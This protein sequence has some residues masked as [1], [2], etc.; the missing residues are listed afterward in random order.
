[1][2]SWFWLFLHILSFMTCYLTILFH[3]KLYIPKTLLRSLSW[4]T[5]NC[6]LLL[7]MGNLPRWH[8]IAW[9]G[10]ALT[11]LYTQFQNPLLVCSGSAW[12]WPCAQLLQ[13]LVPP[14]TSPS[15]PHFVTERNSLSRVG[16]LALFQDPCVS[17]RSLPLCFLSSP[18]PK[19]PWAFD[20]KCN[21]LF[22]L[23]RAVDLTFFQETSPLEIVT[24]FVPKVFFF[25]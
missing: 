14:A 3:F 24:V 21:C 10:R 2:K 25:P 9:C 4:E 12:P 7:A 17:K 1:M 5:T 13:R 6:A 11:R 16:G 8:W 19:N 22:A 15:S 20:I 23:D 18:I